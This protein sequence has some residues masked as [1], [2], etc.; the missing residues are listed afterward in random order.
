MNY[1]FMLTSS[2]SSNSCPRPPPPPPPPPP[3]HRVWTDKFITDDGEIL[4][5]QK[6]SLHW[7]DVGCGASAFAVVL[8]DT[9]WQPD[10]ANQ[11]L[12]V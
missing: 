4:D 5:P 12:L 1:T 6:L 10:R 8:G 7:D 2:P 3:R 11:K 9:N